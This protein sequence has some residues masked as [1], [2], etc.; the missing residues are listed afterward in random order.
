MEKKR[1]GI[2]DLVNV[3][4]FTAI[5][6]VMFFISGMTGLIPVMTIFY[7]VL[8]AMLGGIPCI[9]FFTKTD[10]FGL[11]TIMGIL[12]GLITFIMGYG[13]YAIGTGVV[14]GL[15]ADFV[16]RAG[17]YKSWKHMLIGYCV[18]SEWAV[19]SQLIMFIFKDAYLAGYIETQGQDYA[20]AVSVLLK[21]YMIPVVIV[22]VAVGALIGA[23][24]GKA[25]LK[26]HFKRAGIA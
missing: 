6:F 16:M 19:G 26:K 1:I 23:Y 7:P 17:Q 18:F 14:C 8:L 2:K 24:L 22:A 15:V 20:D 25:T 12:L 4:I 5:Y 10:K 13:P 3:G 9:L 21:D 11:V